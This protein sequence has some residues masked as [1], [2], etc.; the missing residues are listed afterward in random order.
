MLHNGKKTCFFAQIGYN[1][2]MNSDFTPAVLI[3]G[4]AVRLGRITALLLAR[5]GWQVAIHYRESAADAD[6]AVEELR[7]CGVK[8]V[9]VQGDLMQVEAADIVRKAADGLGM[10]LTALVNNAAAFTKNNLHD[11]TRE[12]WL[13]HMDTNLYAPLALTRAFAVQ[14]PDGARGAVVNLIDGCE[15]MCLSPNFLTYTLS[16]QGLAEAT[17]LLAKELAPAIRV[18]GVSPGLTLP[19]DGEEEMFGRLV[20]RLPLQQATEPEDIAGAIAYFLETASIT[21]QILALDGG[22]GLR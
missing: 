7:A 22:A 5:K 21:G 2:G 9:A 15:A 13:R 19:K 11:F 6:S 18:N 3:T 10:P 4:G 16:K 1:A 14:L 17:R 8:A 20:A 12:G